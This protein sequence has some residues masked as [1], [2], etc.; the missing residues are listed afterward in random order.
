MSERVHVSNL[1][2]IAASGADVCCLTN[3][4]LGVA[5]IC[6]AICVACDFRTF[7]V[8]RFTEMKGTDK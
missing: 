5:I 8:E 7:L 6:I 1:A 4:A 2:G 3:P